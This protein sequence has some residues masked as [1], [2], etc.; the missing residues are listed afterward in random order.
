MPSTLAISPPNNSNSNLDQCNLIRDVYQCSYHPLFDCNPNINYIWRAND[1][2]D[3]QS[4]T[5]AFPVPVQI[6]NI[7]A[8]VSTPTIL[9][10][11]ISS[12]EDNFVRTPLVN[13]RISEGYQNHVSSFSPGVV[14][15]K[16]DIRANSDIF[17]KIIFCASQ[18]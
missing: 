14:G 15:L 18:G 10:M 9:Q 12:V 7:L 16:I 4:M 5:A 2:T 8:Y 1:F 6:V 17:M 3:L 13:F 11:Q